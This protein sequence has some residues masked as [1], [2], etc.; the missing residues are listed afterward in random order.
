M[1]TLQG[2]LAWGSSAMSMEWS[3]SS[4]LWLAIA[5]NLQSETGES[6]GA[7]DILWS[8]HY[9]VSSQQ[10]TIYVTRSQYKKQ[11]KEGE[12]EEEA[13]LLLLTSHADGPSSANF[14]T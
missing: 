5:S 1:A 6:L 12:K 2:T 9:A 11:T 7:R 10:T 3:P 14:K 13:L 4:E 8:S